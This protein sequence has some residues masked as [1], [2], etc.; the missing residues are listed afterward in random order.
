MSRVDEFYPFALPIASPAVPL[1]D[2]NS[3]FLF[4]L[5]AMIY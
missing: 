1:V 4:L 3:K 2:S 5:V